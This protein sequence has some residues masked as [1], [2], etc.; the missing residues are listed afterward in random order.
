MKLFQLFVPK[1]Y[2]VLAR[3]FLCAQLDRSPYLTIC[4]NVL[5]VS[6]NSKRFKT[7]F[8]R[9]NLKKLE[10]GHET[11]KSFYENSQNR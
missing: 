6:E 11:L 1:R 10:K 4:M 2:C 3:T 9:E 7:F 5:T 8:K